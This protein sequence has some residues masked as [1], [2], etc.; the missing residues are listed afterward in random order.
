MWA[1]MSVVVMAVGGALALA[2][3]A[4]ADTV[5]L[6]SA[7]GTPSQSLCSAG[8]ECTYVPF[9][10]VYSPALVVPY[11]GTVTSFA[12]NSGSTG[13]TVKL[14]VVRPAAGGRFTGAGTSAAVTIAGGVQS[15]TTSLPVRTGDVIGLE[16]D[17]SA[18]LFDNGTLTTFTAYY[19]LPALGD[20]ASAAPSNVRSDRRLLLSAVLQYTKPTGGGGSSGGGTVPGTPVVPQCVVPKLRNLTLAKAKQALTAAQCKLGKVTRVRDR[21]VKRGRV[22]S[23]QPDA[24]W[25]RD[26]GAKV[27]VKVSLGSPQKR[28]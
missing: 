1:R 7:A 8:F 12:I 21:R 24:K 20:G 22:I 23:Q 28:R 5:T 19:Q 9:S 2:P 10:N 16:N 6:G 25:R 14:R 15:A 27:A 11:D 26:V 17:N 13:G 4:G 3:A 18:V